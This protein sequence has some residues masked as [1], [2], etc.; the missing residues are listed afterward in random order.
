[1]TT[2]GTCTTDGAGKC[3]MSVPGAGTYG[4]S[5]A[6]AGYT[7]ATG[8]VVVSTTGITNNTINVS[9]SS[10]FGYAGSN[11]NLSIGG[12]NY[13]LYY[14]GHAAGQYSWT[15]N[16]SLSTI[17]RPYTATF[18]TTN[19]VGTI[20]GGVC[21][22]VGTAN[23][24]FEATFA[25]NDTTG[26]SAFGMTWFETQCTGFGTCGTYIEDSNATLTIKTGPTTITGNVTTF[27]SFPLDAVFA[28]PANSAFASGPCASGVF[29]PPFHG[30][31]ATVTP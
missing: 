19:G 2:I 7:T 23:A 29:H 6:L 21:T 18:S 11:L 9:S 3:C 26:C 22:A 14:I 17:S 25:I 27:S 12:N 10:I 5:V 16:S 15:T 30:T 20:V 8:S 28:I 1:M 4:V 24:T 31:N 13:T